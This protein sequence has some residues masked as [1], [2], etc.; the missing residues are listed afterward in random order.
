MIPSR[1]RLGG[2]AEH[3]LD[4][5]GIDVVALVEPVV[6]ADEHVARARRGI[7]L[8]LDLHAVAARRDVDAEAVAR[9]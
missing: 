3:G 5:L 6:E 2:H 1:M 4:R 8:A 7:G 9:S